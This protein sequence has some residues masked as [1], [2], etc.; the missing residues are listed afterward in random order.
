MSYNYVH[1]DHRKNR[2]QSIYLL[3]TMVIF[4]GLGL[5][6]YSNKKRGVEVSQEK[7]VLPN[8]PDGITKLPEKIS[9]KKPNVY[10][11]SILLMD[12][13]TGYILYSQNPDQQIPIASTTKIMTAIV[14]LENY[15]LDEIIT[16]SKE[17]VQ[18][19]GSDIQLRTD[20]KM[21]VE[22]LLEGLLINSG[23]D[24]AYAL[25]LKAGSIEKFAEMMNI[26]AKE[27]GLK[28]TL[29]KNPA[30]LDDT[31]YSTARDLATT[32]AYAMRNPK[33]REIV[34]IKEKTI[35][36]ADGNISHDLKNSNRLVGEFDYPGAIGIKTGYTP[37]AGHAL[38]AAVERKNRM[39]ISVVLNTTESTITASATESRKLFDWTYAT[40]KFN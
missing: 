28:N 17:A 9:D 29:F 36:S 34:K 21:T 10:A 39:L 35:Y 31:A 25:A 13:P 37:E 22:N 27:I 20:E 16:I 40:F 2:K 12:V 33:F 15:K 38:V 26:K 14:V 3:L 7:I 11:K 23:N 8:L 30:G 6:F 4:F 32:A 5:I 19:I 1:L 18:A 24:A